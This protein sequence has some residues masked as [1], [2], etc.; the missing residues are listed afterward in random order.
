VP[1]AP[2]QKEKKTEQKS[3]W[4]TREERHVTEEAFSTTI[5]CCYRAVIRGA[6]HRALCSRRHAA[7]KLSIG[8]WDHWVPGA[9]K[10]R[11]ICQ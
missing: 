11:P 8:F 2:N 9:N 6:D 1:R 4:L 3:D 7:G 5:C 10:A